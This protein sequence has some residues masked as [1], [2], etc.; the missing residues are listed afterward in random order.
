[1]YFV[2]PTTL[3]DNEGNVFD[4]E[5]GQYQSKNERSSFAQGKVETDSYFLAGDKMHLDD[6]RGIY[7]IQNNVTMIAKENDVIISGNAAIYDKKNNI[8]KVYD[9][10]VMRLAA[11]NDTLFVTAD[12][13]VSIDSDDASKK[14]LLAYSNV[15]IYKTDIQGVADSLAYVVA[16]S[17]LQMFG[18]PVLWSDENQMSADSI[19][20][21]VSGG[22]V[23]QMHMRNN[24]FVITK[25]SSSNFNQIKGRSMHVQFESDQLSEVFV[26]GNGESIFFMY[27]DET[28]LLMGMNKI[29]CSDIGLYFEDQILID[30]KFFVSPEGDF[31]PPHLLKESDRQLKGFVWR[32]AER[33]NK[34]DLVGTTLPAPPPAHDQPNQS[35]EIPN[36][37]IGLPEH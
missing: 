4:Y 5:G 31:I 28:G 3:T 14:R 21:I 22:T 30:A 1:M 16:D 37:E 19:M 12:T 24:A 15:K 35:L 33:P 26:S 6:I 32:G 13:L 11:E 25:D 29:I 2:A 34:V 17:T 10:P 9:H 18:S 7:K 8:T 23:E 20:I 36:K 27:N